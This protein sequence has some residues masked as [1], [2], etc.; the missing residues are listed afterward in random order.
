VLS[1]LGLVA[2]VYLFCRDLFDSVTGLLA[3]LFTAVSP[4]MTAMSIALWPDPP[5][6]F[7]GTLGL[8]ALTRW[9]RS[10]SS[11]AF[12]LGAAA[13][14]LSILLKL[15][16]LYLGLPILYL[17]YVRYGPGFWKQGRV[18][19]L[20]G[21]VLGAPLLWYIYAHTLYLEYH[22]TFGIVTGGFLKFATTQ[23]LLDPS[24]YYLSLGRMIFYHFT[25]IAFIFFVFGL[26]GKQSNPLRYLF[27]IWFLAVIV[28]FLVAARGVSIGH[29]QYML[30]VVPPGAALAGAGA[31]ILL[32][33]IDLSR[34]FSRWSANL[35]LV[36]LAV[37]FLAGAVWATYV[38]QVPKYTTE[39]WI[40]DRETGIAVGQH[41]PPGSLIIVVDNQMGGPPEGI[42][43]PPNVFYFSDRK[44]WYVALS[45]L[46]GDLIE[47]R[48]RAGAQFLVIT[49]N[50]V[51]LFEKEYA[52]AESYLTSRYP[53]V[54]NNEAGTM[55]DLR[56]K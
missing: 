22:N 30:P 25:P 16:G 43:T 50:T 9:A 35:V 42:M 4:P 12:I 19:V 44:G 15:T 8:Y 52:G 47:Q 13:I 39:E 11:G 26:L 46:N 10:G 49:A 32:R 24:F 7:C 18:W 28:Y 20:A 40:H 34:W 1:G 3:G 31:L 23:I 38:Y 27:H 51:L 17:C 53:V 37:L 56:S 55:Y 14:S 29:F 36:V 21:L 48:R 5:M 54:Y 41:T 6:I 45:W 2:V 33:K